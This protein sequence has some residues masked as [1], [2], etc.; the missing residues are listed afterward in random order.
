LFSR[1]ENNNFFFKKNYASEHSEPV[2][3]G[4]ARCL[5]Q[6]LDRGAQAIARGADR[7][8]SQV[9]V[10]CA[11]PLSKLETLR[12]YLIVVYEP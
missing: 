9:L 2:A 8:A 12:M 7:C 6:V 1:E 4:D 5:S 11:R 3:R 10:R